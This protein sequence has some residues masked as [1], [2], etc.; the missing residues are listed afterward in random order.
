MKPQRMITTITLRHTPYYVRS[1]IQETPNPDPHNPTPPIQPNK[2]E[3]G[4]KSMNLYRTV[5]SPP[6]TISYQIPTASSKALPSYLSIRSITSRSHQPTIV[7]NS[8]H[9][10][11]ILT[12]NSRL[13]TPAETLNQSC[14]PE[15]TDSYTYPSGTAVL[16]TGYWVLG[17]GYWVLGTGYWVL[18]TGYWVLGTGY[19]ARVYCSEQ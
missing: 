14:N 3:E 7:D 10:P 19:W 17:T 9:D 6:P 11:C 15:Y 2:S 18:G 12:S 13:A 16:D 1:Y 8:P 5:S 4:L